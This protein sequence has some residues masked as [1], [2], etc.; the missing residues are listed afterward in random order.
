MIS[1]YPQTTAEVAVVGQIADP[2]SGG[3]I[4]AYEAEGPN[5]TAALES[6]WTICLGYRTIQRMEK[7]RGGNLRDLRSA[8]TLQRSRTAI[9]LR[10]MVS[11]SCI[12]V[13]RDLVKI[14]NGSRQKQM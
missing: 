10:K 13:I 14:L 11:F 2:A 6:D 8:T 4:R 1:I 9:V 5:A 3:V 7:R 12:E